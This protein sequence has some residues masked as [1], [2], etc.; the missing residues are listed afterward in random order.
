MTET[1]T[2]TINK[3]LQ[4]I[5]SKFSSYND[6]ENENLKLQIISII[7]K[8]ITNLQLILNSTKELKI[9]LQSIKL[10]YDNIEI[11]IQKLEILHFSKKRKSDKLNDFIEYQ[12][13]ITKIL[14]L[15]DS[16]I[17]ISI[18]SYKQSDLSIEPLSQIITKLEQSLITLSEQNNLQKTKTKSKSSTSQYS[19]S[20]YSSSNYNLQFPFGSK[21]PESMFGSIRSYPM[22]GSKQP[23]SMFGSKQPESNGIISTEDLI[24]K[25]APIA[26]IPAPT[27]ASVALAVSAPQPVASTAASSS[28]NSEQPITESI[29]KSSDDLSVQ[30]PKRA[31]IEISSDDILPKS[32]RV[33]KNKLYGVGDIVIYNH[34]YYCVVSVIN[35]IKRDINKHY[36]VILMAICPKH[37]TKDIDGKFV[38]RPTINHV[39][40]TKSVSIFMES[41]QHSIY[42]QDVINSFEQV[43]TVDYIFS[44][45]YEKEHK[46][47]NIKT[48]SC[49]KYHEY[50]EFVSFGVKQITNIKSISF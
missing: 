38:F 12:S 4:E 24:S 50:V 45:L 2:R 47:N 1:H 48:E 35:T 44:Y 32:K 18:K 43:D 9:D 14:E 19:S 10:Q 21:Q 3:Y 30:S 17:N 25:V 31:K 7:N 42:K 29:D 23:E 28:S 37:I 40:S 20:S 36:E 15:L 26:P 39:D 27:I 49:D 33:L 16:F 5:I 46:L 22:F 8:F 11:E 13:L 41:K 6:L 34:I